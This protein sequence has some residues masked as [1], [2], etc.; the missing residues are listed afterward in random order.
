MRKSA[1]IGGALA[2]GAATLVGTA[3]HAGSSDEAA[4]RM[5]GQFIG[6]IARA[7][8]HHHHYGYGPYHYAP[9]AYGYYAPPPHPPVYYRSGRGAHEHWCASHHNNYDPLMNTYEMSNGE[10]TTCFSPYD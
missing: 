9:P 3:A 7:Q 2:I 6:T 4:L 1:I 8:Q 5:F 10:R